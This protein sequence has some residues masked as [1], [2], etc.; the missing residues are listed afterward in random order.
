MTIPQTKRQRQSEPIDPGWDDNNPHWLPPPSPKGIN[1]DDLFK[2][3]GEWYQIV[4]RTKAEPIRRCP[5][6]EGE[7]YLTHHRKTIRLYRRWQ[8]ASS[9]TQ[10]EYLGEVLKCPK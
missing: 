5:L 7:L 6:G 3:A 10:S 4:C 2:I 8:S 1:P 9:Q